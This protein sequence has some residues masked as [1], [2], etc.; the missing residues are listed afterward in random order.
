[1]TWFLFPIM[2]QEWGPEGD[3]PP[4]LGV[5]H[6]LTM[7]S[8]VATM[9]GPMVGGQALKAIKPNRE[10]PQMSQL[11]VQSLVDA[12]AHIGCRV[13]RWNPK[14]EPFIY[15]SRNRIH[16]I[17]L[18]ETIRGILRAR[19]FLK[20][21]VGSGQDVLFV[22][23]KP[24]IRAEVAKVNEE[25]GMP[26]VNDRWIG[27]TL[28][29]YQIIGSR[30]AHLDDLEKKESEGYLDD[31]TKKEAARFLREKRK[32]FRNLHGIRDMFRLPG[33]LVVIDPRTEMNAVREAQ[34]MG[35]PVVGIV[36][37]D[38]DPDCC[39]LIIPA[40][41]DAIRSVGLILGHLM[42]AVE[43]GKEL[44]RERGITEA[45]KQEPIVALSAPIPR[46]RSQRARRSDGPAQVAD[47]S[48]TPRPSGSR[49]KPDPEA[50]NRPV[51]VT[52]HVAETAAPAEEAAAP[53]E[54]TPAESLPEEGA[55]GEEK[56]AGK[57]S[58]S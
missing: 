28:T 46:P 49:P 48:P 16:V 14:M 29:N 58:L 37:T 31:L 25:T 56:S 41:D 50:L 35:I 40:N 53:A 11:S 1:M 18:K 22:G 3:I 43:K 27:G 23:T 20:E 44:R 52:P 19:H 12:G 36:D 6:S 5:A 45:S 9:C 51:E 10:S 8:R 21:M 17:D 13:G 47:E 42:E 34:R 2:A 55:D 33:A 54:D 30:I 57:D 4:S 32:I 39:D 24:Q 38:G 26:F 15:G 7:G